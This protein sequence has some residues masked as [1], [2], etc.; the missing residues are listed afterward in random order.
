MARRAATLARVAGWLLAWALAS[1]CGQDEPGSDGVAPEAAAPGSDGPLSVVLITLDTTRADALSL[2]GNERQ[3]TPEI[4]RFAER[5]AVFEQAYTAQPSTLPSHATIMTGRLPFAHGARANA[6]YVLAYDNETLAEV[7]SRNGYVTAAEIA[8][9]VIGRQTQLDQGFDHYRDLHSFD[10]RRKGVRVERQGELNR[11][12]L[13]ERDAIDITGRGLEFLRRSADE[14][15]FLWL[16]YFD[17]HSFYVP[18]PPWNNRFADLPYYSEIHFTDYNVGRIIEELRKLGIS[19]RTLVVITSDHGEGLGEHAEHTHS[20]FVYDTTMRVPLAFVLP[21]TIAPQLRIE[22]PV[23][24]VD[25]APTVLDLAGLPPLDE[26]QGV[27]L[28]PLLRGREVAPQLDVYGE[29]FEPLSLFGSNVLRFVRRG[30]W[31][32]IHKVNPELFDLSSDAAELKNL[33]AQNPELVAQLRRAMTEWVLRERIVRTDDRAYIDEEMLDQLQALGYMGEGAPAGFDEAEDLAAL[34]DVDPVDRLSDMDTY[35]MAFAALKAKLPEKALEY[36]DEL[37]AKNPDS[38]PVIRGLLGALDDEALRERGPA[39]LA[40]AKELDPDNPV[41]FIKAAE[42]QN[43]LGD[44]RTA[45]NELRQ[46]LV[47]DP[48]NRAARVVFADMLSQWGRV[49]DQRAL[50]EEGIANCE[51]NLDFRNDLAYLLA[52]SKLDRLAREVVAET[53]IERPDFLDTLACAWAEV[54]NFRNAVRHSKRAVELIEN[55][56]LGE[57]VVT[58]YRAHLDQF[59]NARPVRTGS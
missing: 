2:Y 20:Y 7:F 46:A 55:S 31:K 53:D 56:D 49:A 35:S 59:E 23:R 36:L 6:G 1:G 26:I 19:E 27:S 37:Y 3:T 12:E 29:S 21:G 14:P 32:Y 47:L 38:M 25:I 48:C 41:H 54:G 44:L 40:K 30:N 33:A 58:E 18:P 13:P 4:D 8:A 45:E 10:I 43:D 34:G 50:L 22:Q 28:A 16:H 52:T 39:L 15:F 17:P 51:M 42:V 24:T 11:Q 57:E 5:G 9:P